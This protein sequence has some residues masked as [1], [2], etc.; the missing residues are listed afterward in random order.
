MFSP[1]KLT[2][3]KRSY[4]LAFSFIATTLVASFLVTGQAIE[5]NSGD[6]RVINLSGRQR[7]LSQRLVKDAL[8]LARQHHAAP[9]DHLYVE[10]RTSLAAWERS[11]D[12]LQYG[13]P[14]L[15]LP[16]RSQSAKVRRLFAE[17]SA[18]HEAMVGA[19]RELL[20]VI[21]E[22]RFD[23]EAG[24][25]AVTVMLANEDD[26]V[27][28]MDEVTLQFEAEARARV[29]SLQRLELLVLLAGLLV[30]LFEMVVVFRPSIVKLEAS[31][32]ALTASRKHL[33]AANESLAAAATEAHRLAEL[34]DAASRA[35]SDFLANMS[36]EIRT[37]MNAIV[38]FSEI[39]VSA[40]EDPK[41]RGHANTILRSSEAL[42]RVINDILDLS[43]VEAG[44]LPVVPTNFD[45]RSL[46]RDIGAIF[47]GTAHQK[48]LALVLEPD[49][50]LPQA[51]A[52]DEVRLRQVLLNLVGNALK[53]TRAGSVVVR[54][55]AV[56]PPEEGA[57]LFR[58]VLEVEDTGIG[59]PDEEKEAV[60][61]AFEQR[62]NQDHA[63]YGGSG[64]GLAISRQLVT[65]LGGTLTL[66]D[67][68]AGQGSRFTVTL[69]GVPVVDA[70]PPTQAELERV[71]ASRALL[72]EDVKLVRS[73]RAP[74]P[75]RFLA[76]VGDAVEVRALCEALRGLL[77]EELPA[78]RHTVRP[79]L[80]EA[81]GERAQAL[82]R[83]H[84]LPSLE[85]EGA[86]L[87]A[88]AAS[89]SITR[90]R[91]SLERLT[92]LVA[93]ILEAASAGA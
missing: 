53:F 70:E 15:G 13:A 1:D 38:G 51:M 32:V 5:R 19:T 58:L 27:R 75:G 79:K 54:A 83:A 89:F 49:D 24:D 2:R 81:L 78:L 80:A 21:A 60:F 74:S 63:V 29:N 46:L 67:N 28:L 6:A 47:E 42:L 65:L 64:L 8:A 68:P 33:Q 87:S 34:A 50:S 88:G 72:L 62:K 30:L 22:G 71:A 91:A 35:K 84:R 31:I 77:D 25:R 11:H 26:F 73:L 7:M 41:L 36:H 57:R 66:T 39:L 23:A 43:R 9:G 92:Q 52:L 90:I 69:E 61:A 82:G 76:E 59:V 40:L 86:E 44:K 4:A 12:G 48:G 3:I 56:F 20:G 18:P 93:R 16:S 10:L 55:E 85:S 17:A 45:L 37:P 14:E